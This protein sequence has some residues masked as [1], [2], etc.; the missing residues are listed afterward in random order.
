MKKQVLILIFCCA[1]T[2]VFCQAV[3]KMK[4]IFLENPSFESNPEASVT[5]EEWESFGPKGESEPDTQPGAFECEKPAYHGNTYLGMVVRDNGTKEAVCQK[6]SDILGAGKSYG[7]GIWLAKS[8]TYMSKSSTTGM[9]ANYDEPCVLRVWAIDKEHD[10]IEELGNTKLVNHTDW[11]LY[12]FTFTPKQPC[13]R[14]MLEV[15]FKDGK[16]F[17]N[18]NILVD[19]ISEIYYLGTN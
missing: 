15:D 10:K 12:E 13:D 7:F 14:I 16:N 17:Y 1:A 3:E 2:T 19:D 5:P 18:G 4:D 9:P 8:D 6:L 11:Q